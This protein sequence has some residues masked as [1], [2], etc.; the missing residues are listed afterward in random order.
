MSVAMRRIVLILLAAVIGLAAYV[1][2]T[3]GSGTPA[4]HASGTVLVHVKHASLTDQ[5]CAGQPISGGHFVI[6]QIASPPSSINVYLS[7]GSTAT[8]PLSKQTRSVGQYTLSF[9][10]G[11]SILD[12]TAAV[13]SGWSGQFVLS[14]YL[15]GGS[16]PTSTGSMP[17]PPSGS[18]HS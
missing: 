7:D 11:L 2:T 1:A 14:N 12:A 3:S 17:P 10:P 4:A 8:V 16:T 15:C 5:G 13:P 9:T 6:N 18:M